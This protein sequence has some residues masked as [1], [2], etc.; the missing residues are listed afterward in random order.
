VPHRAAALALGFVLLLAAPSAAQL[1][2]PAPPG[3]YVF[4]VRAVLG[5]FPADPSFFPP[6]P[7]GTVVPSRGFGIDLGGHVYLFRIGPARLGVGVNVVRLR[8]TT[9]PPEPDGPTGT[10][11]PPRTIPDVDAT[12]T[13][14]APQVS[15]NFGSADGW[16]YLSAGMGTA[17]MTTA[18]SETLASGER[19][20]GRLSAINVG[21]GA[22]WFRNRHMAFAFDVRFHLVSARPEP[23]PRLGTPKTTLVLAS[24][25][26]SLR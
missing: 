20:T 2:A 4:D 9:S 16:S 6:V 5:G 17:H 13:A 10:S 26:L 23:I 12:L 22:R 14:L 1:P 3:P 18:T 21:G 24:V 25:G 15:F 7:A 19:N 11:P 8:H